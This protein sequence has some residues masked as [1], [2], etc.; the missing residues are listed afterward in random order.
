MTTAN[1]ID[2]SSW[3]H[4]SGKN[5]DWEAVKTSGHVFVMVKASQGTSYRNP[6]F[7]ADIEAARKAG[8]L[9]GAYHFAEPSQHPATDEAAYALQSIQGVTLDLG[10]ALDLE[11]IG[12][13]PPHDVGT[14]A[15]AFLNAVGATVN[16]SPLYCDQS[17]F[18]QMVGAP[19]GHPLWIADPSGT[20]QGT[21]WMRQGQP[22]EITGI[23][24]NV[25][26]DVLTNIRGTNPGPVGPPA[27]PPGGTTP[28]PGPVTP[29]P[30]PAPAGGPP[31]HQEDEVQVP[32]LSIT[33]PGP[34][35]V[36]TP[37]KAVQAILQ[38]V[39]DISPGSSGF[40]GKFG[41]ETDQAVRRFQALQALTVDGVVGPAT[42][43]KLCNG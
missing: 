33:D 43:A 42:W 7:R 31:E 1:G 35:V 25:D 24:G 29:P 28:A 41:P 40:D 21:P 27:L 16:P 19:W 36:S 3:Q 2:I 15:E 26:T 37:V 39:A 22:Q 5:I 10:L 9:V 11:D 6:T 18:T 34:E 8:L 20:F 23:T 32:T 38:G 30:A 14:W 17:L 4:N 13:L 12:T